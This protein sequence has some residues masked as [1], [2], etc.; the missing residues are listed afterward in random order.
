V[1]SRFA[2]FSILLAVLSSCAAGP[3]AHAPAVNVAATSVAQGIDIPLPDTPA[4]RVLAEWLRATNTGTADELRHF[5]ETRYSP[6][7]NGP[8]AVDARVRFLMHRRAD[9]GVR[10]LRK[11]E[12]STPYEITVVLEAEGTGSWS[13]MHAKLDP[14]PLHLVVEAGGDPT[15]RPDGFGD[16][17]ALDD[18][19]L[20]AH[21]D[22]YVDRLSK[23]DRFSGAIAVS[24]GAR[25]VY[26]RAAGIASLAWNAPMRVDTK[27]NLGSMNKMFTSVAIA[28]L[29]A[30]GKMA[31]TDTLAKLV[32][33]YPN[34]DVAR[35][36]TIHQLLTHSSGL[37][38]YFTDA[39]QHRAKNELR[40]V[41]DYF[42]LF[43]D[44]PLLFEP[45]ARFSYSNAGFMVLGAVIEKVSGQDYFAYVREHVCAPAGMND[46]D[47]YEMD[48]DTPN[49]AIGYTRDDADPPGVWTNNLYLHVVKGGPA[50]GGFSTVGDLLRFASA[51]EHGTILDR[52]YVARITHKQI[53]MEG[54]EE[55]YGYGFGLK[56]VR[57][58][59][60]YGHSGGFDGI[61][62]NFTVVPDLQ[63]AVAVLA[64]RDPPTAER[65]AMM[66][67]D[68]ATQR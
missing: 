51:L 10:H 68:Y 42:P 3:S 40:A 33:D 9:E 16:H 25:V 55:T 59:A 58:H 20:A 35:R 29:V 18:A 62:G 31:Y 65:L 54:E 27:M 12:R 22:A 2:V 67:L 26:Q 11:I 41:R 61:N 52:E 1:R 28:Q 39:Y 6:A 15:M 8:G 56:T 14:G 49:L 36:I 45:G 47:A 46:T 19:A 34:Q 37:G 21:L 60:T 57:G 66:A 63:L 48:H 38:D 44:E 13:R 5:Y 32:P 53:A 7:L 64:N 4:G 50:G 23:A 24:R 30:Q 43:V 17:G